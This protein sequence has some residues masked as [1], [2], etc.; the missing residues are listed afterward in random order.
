MFYI[1]LSDTGLEFWGN[2]SCKSP[3][4]FDVKMIIFVQFAIKKS[5]R[6]ERIQ[7]RLHTAV[8]LQVL[9]FY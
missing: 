5:V 1:D 2:F 7:Q 3:F 4:P 8:V 6:L 9:F